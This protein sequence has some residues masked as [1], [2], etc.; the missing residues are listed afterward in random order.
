MPSSRAVWP[1]LL[2]AMAAWGVNLSAVK[3]LTATFDV[4]TLSSV[5][6]VVGVLSLTL[7]VLWRQR[8]LPTFTSRELAAVV[9]CGFLMVYANQILFGGGL[10]L[11][12]ATNGALIVALGPIAS[13]SLASLIFRESVRPRRLTGILLGLGG[14]MLVV[15][16]RPGVEFVRSGLGDLLML[17]SVLCFSAG[18]I[19][20]Q[21]I[22]V[23]TDPLSIGWAVH[24]VGATLLVLHTAFS[25]ELAAQQLAS[26]N[27]RDWGLVLFSGAVATGLAAVVWYQSISTIGV[28]RTSLA[29]YW[30]P[31][32]GL[33]FAAMVMGEPV[34]IWHLAGLAAVL[35]GSYLGSR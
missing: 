18:G 8:R 17:C 9:V 7:I 23:R 28:A 13:A 10:G 32:F 21:K 19:T 33:A 16:N 29:F 12:S 1:F 14:V 15:L 22:A 25:S 6:M 35:T 3:A 20:V 30:V 27:W 2:A 24:V 31:I 26:A 11:T 34:T 4:M 5:R